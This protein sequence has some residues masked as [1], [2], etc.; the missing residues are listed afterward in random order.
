MPAR[1][2]QRPW[3]RGCCWRRRRAKLIHGAGGAAVADGA[4]LVSARSGQALLQSSPSGGPQAGRA[5]LR[6]GTGALLLC[7]PLRLHA[8]ACAA[9][10]CPLPL[11]QECREFK[12][13]RCSR[14]DACRFNHVGG[15]PANDSN[16][17][18]YD[19]HRFD[20][21]D[22]S[23]RARAIDAPASLPRKPTARASQQPTSDYFF[24]GVCVA[25]RRTAAAAR[26]ADATK[27]RIAM[28]AST[29][30]AT[31]SRRTM[32]RRRRRP[33]QRLPRPWPRREQQQLTAAT[34]AG[35][36]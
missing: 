33:A 25:A 14:G 11:P 2:G 7:L 28:I 18:G 27:T 29:K 23:C 35:G 36:G 3:T 16:G 9:C 13:G 5:A 6:L 17:G 19:E 10:T 12:M 30:S 8:C 32:T 20:A 26:V 21:D 1:S 4:G 22:V 15:P 24:S 31:S 34:A